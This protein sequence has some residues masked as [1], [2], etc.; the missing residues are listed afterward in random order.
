MAVVG[1]DAI[2]RWGHGLNLWMKAWKLFAFDKL[3]CVI[4]YDAHGTRAPAMRLS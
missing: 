1:R 2:S 3:R 4:E